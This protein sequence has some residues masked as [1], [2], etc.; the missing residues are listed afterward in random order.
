MFAKFADD[1]TPAVREILAAVVAQRKQQASPSQQPTQ[2]DNDNDIASMTTTDADSRG[3]LA[4]VY[5]ARLQDDPLVTQAMVNEA[6]L[7][8]IP[9]VK[10]TAD[11]GEAATGKGA[12]KAR[13]EGPAPSPY[14][15]P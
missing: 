6:V 9:H 7:K 5:A 11:C 2:P 4:A 14:T 3:L 1:D 15:K 8:F 10:A 13:S 12:G